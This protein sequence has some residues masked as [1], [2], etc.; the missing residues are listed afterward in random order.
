MQQ[1]RLYLRPH[2]KNFLRHS[3][4]KKVLDYRLSAIE[5]DNLSCHSLRGGYQCFYVSFSYASY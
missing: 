2:G 4:C 5:A 1:L 3:S